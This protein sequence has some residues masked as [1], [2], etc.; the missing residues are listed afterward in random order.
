MWFRVLRLMNTCGEGL[1]RDTFFTY[2]NMAHNLLRPVNKV[3]YGELY[4]WVAHV[5]IHPLFIIF[6]PY[7]N[8]FIDDSNIQ[9]RTINT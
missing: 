3:A 7:L 2:C 9:V 1:S 6:I 5:I 4:E 8:L